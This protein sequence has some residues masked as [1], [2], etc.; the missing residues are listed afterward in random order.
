[1]TSQRR[2]LRGF[3]GVL[4]LVSTIGYASA[5][6]ADDRVL[7]ALSREKGLDLLDTT[8]EELAMMLA[9]RMEVNVIVDEKALEEDAIPLDTMLT[10][11]LNVDFKTALR[12]IL[13]KHDLAYTVEEGVLLITT[14]TSCDERGV[15][16]IHSVPKE[17]HADPLAMATIQMPHA[18]VD[19]SATLSSV[20]HIIQV[21]VSPNTWER[22]GGSSAIEVFGNQLVISAP[23]SVHDKVAVLLKNMARAEAEDGVVPIRSS[24]KTLEALHERFDLAFVDMTLEEVAQQSSDLL[25]VQFVV[26]EKALEEDAIPIDTMVTCHL[27]NLEFG[28]ALRLVLRKHDLTWMVTGELV[29]ITTWTKAQE[30]QATAFYP[31]G[32]L[33]SGAAFG[34]DYLIRLLKNTVASDAWELNGGNSTMLA[35]PSHRTLVISTTELV[36]KRVAALLADLRTGWDPRAFAEQRKRIVAV[37]YTV[38]GEESLP[39]DVLAFLQGENSGIEWTDPQT[40]GQVVGDRLVIRHRAEVHMQIKR[41]VEWLAAQTDAADGREF[42]G[43]FDGGGP[44]VP[45]SGGGFGGGSGQF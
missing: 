9:D 29:Q 42:G 34:S 33:T 10:A 32:D 25:G 26:D 2:L 17:L 27:E 24:V 21:S 38:E 41:F 3:L 31:V 13:D 43:G 16:R 36:H 37:A 39:D 35:T 28:G 4:T 19:A 45:G 23:L 6:E 5:D 12:L 7:A 40:N 11:K 30:V 22:F 8:L 15:V 20:V 1:M 44:G 14:R 18:S